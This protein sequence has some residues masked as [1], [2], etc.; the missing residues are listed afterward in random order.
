M[1]QEPPILLLARGT[2]ARNQRSAT[3]VAS[4]PKERDAL[5]GDKSP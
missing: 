5:R 2:S 4:L 3:A 1:H